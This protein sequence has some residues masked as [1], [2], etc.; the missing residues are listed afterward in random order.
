MRG[1]TRYRTRMAQALA[2]LMAVGSAGAVEGLAQS[3]LSAEARRVLDRMDARAKTLN[4]LTADLKQTKVTIVVEDVAEKA[5]KLFYKKSRRKSA[6][7][8]EYQEPVPSIILL[9]KGKVSILEPRIKR[10][11]EV[12]TGNG[13]ATAKL[14]LFWIGRSGRSI[15]RD[16][17]VRHLKTEPVDSRAASL[18]ELNPR[19]TATQGMFPRIQLW[20]DHKYWIPI[21]TRIFE[22]SGD[23]HTILLSNVEINPGLQDRIFKLKVPPDFERMEQKLPPSR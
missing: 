18:L 7:K 21:Q 1:K 13:S 23:Y 10:Y 6:F 19:S 11:Q 14:P 20:V 5:G 8:I 2:I 15:R 17:D 12:D 22:A 3:K 16:N 4:S 9:E